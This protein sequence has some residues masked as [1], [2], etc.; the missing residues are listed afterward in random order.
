M[1]RL[2][3]RSKL[4]F[5][6]L[7]FFFL[8][9]NQGISHADDLNRAEIAGFLNLIAS[10]ENDTWQQ[11]VNELHT[12]YPHLMAESS[13]SKAL[14]LF[15]RK[16]LESDDLNL[17]RL[18]QRAVRNHDSLSAEKAE[19][20]TFYYRHY[21]PSAFL[22]PSIHLTF[23]VTEAKV[24]VTTD[25]T[26]RRNSGECSLIL[27]GKEHDVHQVLINGHLIPKNRYKI[28]PHELILLGVPNDET[29]QV[30]IKSEIDPFSNKSLEGMYQCGQ[31]LTTQ[32][33]SEGARRIFFT[34][35]RP[36]VLSQ[37][38]TTI[39]ADKRL[40]PYRLSNG[41][42]VNEVLLQDGRWEITWNDPF[43]KPSYLFACVLGRFS[44]LTSHFTT[45]SGRNVELQIYVEPGKES[46][47]HYPLFA[48]KKAMEFDEVLFDR[49]YDLSCLK[50]VGI[51]D[52][53][54]GAMENKG[55]MIFNDVRLLVDSDSGTDR[56]HRE[57]ATVIGHEYFHNWSGNRVTIRNWFEIALK[58][59]FT[60]LRAMLFSEWLFG[61][62]F[63]R[64]KSVVALR[65]NQFPEETSEK[66]H[67]MIV[68]SYVDPHSIYDG[69]TYIK[70]REVFRT[71]MNYIDMQIPGGFREVQNLYFS[72]YDGQA[73]TF[74]ELLA[75]GNEVLKHIGQDLSKFERWFHQQGTPVLNARMTYHAKEKIAEIIV[76]QSCPHPKTGMLQEP[77]QIPF[78]LELLGP[79][80]EILHP[81]FSQIL[82]EE[83]TVFKIESA[84]KPTPVF[85]HGYS[86]PVILEYDYTAEDLGCIVKYSDDSFCRWEAGQKY[87]IFALKEMIERIEKDPSLESKAQSG[88]IIFSDLQQLYVQALK[89]TQLSPLS[90]AQL[91]EIPSLRALSQAFKRYDFERLNEYRQLFIRQLALLCKPSLESMLEKYPAP[92][93]YEPRP[94]EM[95]IRELRNACFALLAL[96]DEKYQ[97]IILENYRTA[98]NFDDAVAAFNLCLKIGSPCK[99]FAV[100]HFYD[101]WK[102]DKA[103]FN[104]WLTSQASSQHCTADDMKK[105]E[106]FDGYD[107]TNPNHVRS[108]Y[109]TYVG[110]LSCYH[111]SSGEGYRLIV[112]KII[113]LSAFNPF[114]AHN[115]I[116]VPAFIDFEQLPSQQQAL[117]AKELER[118]RHH[119]QVAPQ[120]RDLVEKMLRWWHDKI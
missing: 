93:V 26:V 89:S 75:A 71:L 13:T 28:T 68:E 103:V 81:K 62:G 39:I 111:H 12:A 116:A 5:F 14:S 80:G 76:K 53:N 16:I 95:Q 110:N 118:L 74:R 101:K 105:L 84:A 106:S 109:R 64:P 72:R 70:G 86:A 54:S 57:V 58:E 94:E 60:D 112:D 32:C 4:G 102:N 7:L 92:Q 100:S 31:W 79:D 99:E 55:L 104:V 2:M 47:A 66:G 98:S 36:D 63:I 91:F 88:L 117:M 43:P 108:I 97:K 114:L 77:L 34:I 21:Q 50:M 46:R 82:E 49:E 37:I 6:N 18:Y 65:E 30:Q 1:L 59:A 107:P 9:F 10:A 52:F 120:T 27:D 44:Q 56:T 40:Y 73:V 48:L 35:D 83:T 8:L 15:N 113:E 51:P 24:L 67:P 61:Q 33:E 78:S 19:P 29:F 3:N 96:A 11:V 69:T 38:T 115:Y 23:D 22:I 25:L 90:K 85:L 119:D 41:D 17:I 42:F 20:F 45:K 87:S